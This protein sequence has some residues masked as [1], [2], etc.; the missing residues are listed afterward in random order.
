WAVDPRVTLLFERFR[1]FDATAT[2]AG[3]RLA[4]GEAASLDLSAARVSGSG[5]RIWGLGWSFEFGR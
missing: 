4:L 2:R 3:V 1:L 5:N